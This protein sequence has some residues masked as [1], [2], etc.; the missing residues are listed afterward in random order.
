M[1]VVFTELGQVGGC[2]GA[3]FLKLGDS[4]CKRAKTLAQIRFSIPRSAVMVFD[5]TSLI[6]QLYQPT[7]DKLCNTSQRLPTVTNLFE[8]I[9]VTMNIHQR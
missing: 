5:S 9:R 2:G 3:E 8:D 6:P 4:K 1:L 7:N